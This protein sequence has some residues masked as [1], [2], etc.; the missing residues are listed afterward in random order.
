MKKNNELPIG[1]HD[2]LIATLPKAI[3][4]IGCVT[5][6]GHLFRSG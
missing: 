3:I 2:T 6:F 1:P 4:N 5:R